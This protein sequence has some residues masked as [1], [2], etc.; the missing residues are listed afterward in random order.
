MRILVKLNDSFV[1]LVKIICGVHKFYSQQHD[2]QTWQK[3]VFM[4]LEEN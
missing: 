2:S 4:Y 3:Q 1:F